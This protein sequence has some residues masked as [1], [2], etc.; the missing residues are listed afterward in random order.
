MEV[1]PKDSGAPESQEFGS[2][3]YGSEKRFWASAM[4]SKK[5]MLRGSDSHNFRFC[6]SF[7]A[8]WG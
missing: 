1:R 7:L 6:G 8:I 4:A 3:R 2:L 5:I